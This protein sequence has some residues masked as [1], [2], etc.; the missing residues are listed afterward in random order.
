MLYYQAAE[1]LHKEIIK[2]LFSFNMLMSNT[3]LVN[4][5][6]NNKFM[7]LAIIREFAVL[8]NIQ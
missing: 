7:T 3:L 4:Y 1:T 6:T 2:I 8:L 5:D